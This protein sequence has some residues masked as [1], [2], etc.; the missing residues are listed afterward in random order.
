MGSAFTP[1]DFVSNVVEVQVLDV[2]WLVANEK[3]FLDFSLVLH[4][5][6]RSELFV[7]DLIKVLVDVYWVENK[8]NIFWRIFIPY[9][10]HLTITLYFLIN[11]VCRE[12]SHEKSGFETFL[13]CLVLTSTA[14]MLYIEYD[15][16]FNSSDATKI[17]R[18]FSNFVNM[19]DL[20][21]YLLTAGIVTGNILN[22]N[23]HLFSE[24]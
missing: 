2:G 22:R 3:T 21:Q 20:T 23:E 5:I 7:S 15:Q 12:D 13:G 16:V 9:I 19:L 24:S 8:W 6:N 1:E 11:V 14:V 4:S 10:L 18:Y 17:K